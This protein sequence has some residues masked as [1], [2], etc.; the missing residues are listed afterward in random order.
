[1]RVP[2]IAF[3]NKMDKVGADFVHSIDTIRTRLGANPVAIQWPVGSESAF[4]GVID[5]LGMRVVS[6]AEDQLLDGVVPTFDE[7]APELQ[8]RVLEVREQTVEQ[9]IETDDGL[10]LLYLDGA[11]IPLAQLRQALRHATLKGQLTP[12]LCGSSLRNKGVKA[13]LDAVVD[14]LPSPLEVPPV[15]GVN[16]FTDKIEQRSVDRNEPFAGLVFK[17]ASDPYVGRLAFF[18]VY[19]GSVKVGTRVTN[20]SKDRKERVTKL[21]RMF[22]DHREELDHLSA[23]DIGA[24]V[25]LK[26]TFTGDTLCSVDAPIVLESIT[27]PEPV[28]WVAI[29]PETAA[30]QDRLSEGLQ[31]LAEEDP[32]FVVRIDENTGQTLISGMGELHL[33][34]LVDRL[35]REFGVRGRVSRPQVSYRETITRSAKGEGLF[36]RQTGGRMQFG[37]VW[38]EIEPLGSDEAVVFDVDPAVRERLPAAFVEGIERGCQEAMESGILG[39]YRVVGVRVRLTNA[40]MDAETS[41]DLAFKVAGTL[42]INQALE[43]AAPVLLEP[44]MDVEVIVPE[45]STGDVMGD[46]NARSAEIREITSR[47]DG[48]QTIR[49]HTP[50]VK[51]FGYA[52]SIRSLTQ[53]RGTF[54]MEF[55]HYAQLDEHRMDAVLYGGGW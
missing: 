34:I 49:A 9:I 40:E 30:D 19:S 35:T 44:V 39:G 45:A 24:T 31:R 54:T 48:L 38:L 16:P 8:R 1:F 41:T 4:S 27:F 2:L 3:I 15:E 42:A 47:A 21:L 51:M 29:E 17:I 5:V 52:T 46:L 36:D 10:M 32:T 12:V 22:A 43:K 33:E 18:R 13:L 26:F 25:G 14:Y 7:L 23:G 6:W 53:G 55:D 20:A 28:I 37:H 50:L 11:D